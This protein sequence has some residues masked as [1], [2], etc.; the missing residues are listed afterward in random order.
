MEVRVD[1]SNLVYE[2][3]FSRETE[4]VGCLSCLPACLSIYLETL[5]NWFSR[6][7]GWQ[8]QNLQGRLAGWKFSQELMLPLKSESNLE[9]EFFSCWLFGR[10][11]SCL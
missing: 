11:H 3:V 7:G 9:G 1:K 4:L 8:V 2:L 6:F 5:R 10:P